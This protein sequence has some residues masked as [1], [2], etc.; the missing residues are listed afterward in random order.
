MSTSRALSSR[1]RGSFSLP[2]S[3]IESRTS[4]SPSVE[5]IERRLEKLPPPMSP[6]SILIHRLPP[7]RP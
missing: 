1:M 7:S 6:T 5:R 4:M 2:A 3:R